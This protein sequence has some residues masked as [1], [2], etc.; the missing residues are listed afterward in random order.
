M[1][2][3][4]FT[5][6]VTYDDQD[7]PHYDRAVDSEFLRQVFHQY[8]SDGVFYGGESDELQVSADTGMQVKVLPGSVHIQGAI[9]IEPDQ[10]TLQVQAA[11]GQDRI[12][13]VVARLDLS[14]AVRS[15]DLYVRKG[16]AAES[17]QAP[18]L[19][20]D[21]TT[22]E[23]GLANLFIA[24]NTTSISAQRITDTRLDPARCGMVGA[25]VQPPFDTAAFFA[26]LQAVIAAQAAA[27]DAQMAEWQAV[28]D[29]WFV[30]I[31]GQL[32]ADAAG[33]LQN[34]VD[35]LA[36]DVRV[37]TAT[38]L[39]DGWV[40]ETPQTPEESATPAVAVYTQTAPCAGLL[41]A[42]D[43]EAPQVESTG[44]Y[45]AD[46]ARKEA[47]DALCEAGNFG[48][49]LDGQLRW[50][51]Y[52]GHPTVDLPLRLRRAAVAAVQGGDQADGG[53]SSGGADSGPDAE[54]VAGNG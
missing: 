51:C 49:T 26:Q 15:I 21:S 5:S 14:Q 40:E 28:F 1:Q 44:E 10:R 50:I 13:T 2:S 16:L 6:R 45:A 34:Q 23:L 8:F 43:L 38:L 53:Q 54:E 41:A 3:Y 37:F 25:P 11:D 30:H 33:H 47:L 42:Y 19:A 17:P 12:D 27:G 29:A 46:L 22:W 48:E 24:A 39:A 35:A 9:G 52:G 31:K 36:A 20:R 4:P 18:A 7:L 32:S